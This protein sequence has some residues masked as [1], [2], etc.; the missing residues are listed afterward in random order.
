MPDG[1]WEAVILAVSCSVD[2]FAASFAYGSKRI[3]IPFLSNQIINLIC[4]AVLGLSL[5]IGASAREIIP[6]GAAK[7][8][9]FSVLLILGIAKLL[10]SVTK[11]LIRK[12]SQ[13]KGVDLRKEIRF[14]M[15]NFN[16]VLSLCADPEKADVDENKV[17]SPA[18]AAAL[19]FSLA[20][21]G[22]AIGFGAGVGDVNVIAAF[23]ASMVTDTA[24]IALG[25]LAGQRL[26][27]AL[28]FNLSWISGVILIGLAAM[29]LI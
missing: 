15:L 8:V 6:T 19:A 21:D 25:C 13:Q 9:S 14:S 16:F 24:A 28:P 12:H 11:S 27:R 22:L 3:R 18:E 5:W 17:I 23:S 1:V 10:D 20:L 26:S 2:A 4:G 29:R 7:A